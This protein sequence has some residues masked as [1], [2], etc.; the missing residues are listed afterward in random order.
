MKPSRSKVVESHIKQGSGADFVPAYTSHNTYYVKLAMAPDS[1]PN[2]PPAPV[3]RETDGSPVSCTEK[4]KVLNDNWAELK[5]IAQDAFEDGL[6]IGC[7]E[8]QLRLI[9][10]EMVD[11]LHN[12]YGKGSGGD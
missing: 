1:R 11:D 10:R 2:A 3:W 9:F 12:P 6:L 4:I 8:E 7:S 5:Q